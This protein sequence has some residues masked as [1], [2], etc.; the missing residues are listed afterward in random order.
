MITVDLEETIQRPVDVVF[1]YLDDDSNAPK[2]QPSVV[3]QHQ[4]SSGPAGVGTT[5]VNVRQVAGQRVETTWEIT[6]YTPTHG[7]TVKSTS[8]PVS[9]ELTYT[10]EPVGAATRVTVHFA[11]E[12]KGFFKLAEPLLAGGIKKDFVEDH[13]RLKAL[14]ESQS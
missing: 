11:G 6:A 8:G 2:W 13:A 4:T 7:F 14:L 3:D 5:G 9:Y 10:L 12:P 1:A